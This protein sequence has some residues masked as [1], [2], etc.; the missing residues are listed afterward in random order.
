MAFQFSSPPVIGLRAVVCATGAGCGALLPG[1]EGG[2]ASY[3]R[4]QLGPRLN[5]GLFH[6]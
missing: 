4:V 1:A 5:A 6:A 2:R 3:P